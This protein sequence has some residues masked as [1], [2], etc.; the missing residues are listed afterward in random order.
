M[1]DLE[2]GYPVVS[3]TLCSFHMGAE[4]ILEGVSQITI[5]I[6]HIE[7]TLSTKESK[8]RGEP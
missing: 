5:D 7:R 8:S 2:R 3:I 4:K 1:L 6:K